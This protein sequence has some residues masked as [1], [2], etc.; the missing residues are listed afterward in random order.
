MQNKKQLILFFMLW[1]TY[2]NSIF[3]SKAVC[4]CGFARCVPNL[5]CLLFTIDIDAIWPDLS[6]FV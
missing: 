1:H 5:A 4:V 3:G 2:N 6:V